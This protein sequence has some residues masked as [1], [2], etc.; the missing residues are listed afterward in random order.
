MMAQA[1]QSIQ[2]KP[3][4]QKKAMILELNICKKQMLL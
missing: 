4:Q 1:V 3:N 2:M